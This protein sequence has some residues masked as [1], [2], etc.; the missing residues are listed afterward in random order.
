LTTEPNAYEAFDPVPVAPPHDA[1]LILR[2]SL[3]D[4][5]ALLDFDARVATT[6]GTLDSSDETRVR[7]R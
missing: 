7:P 1:V 2:D 3:R 6:E 4:P 5:F